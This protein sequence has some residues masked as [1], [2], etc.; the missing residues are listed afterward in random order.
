MK[1]SIKLLSVA[2]LAQ[3]LS[4][5]EQNIYKMIREKTIPADAVVRLGGKTLRIKRDAIVTWLDSCTLAKQEEGVSV[6][7]KWTVSEYFHANVFSV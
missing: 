2:E 4:Y 7:K 1:K 3:R 6:C 5:T